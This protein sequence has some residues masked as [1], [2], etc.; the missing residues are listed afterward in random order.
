MN[1]SVKFK[2]KLMFKNIKNLKNIIL[3][4]VFIP[5][6]L[7]GCAKHIND[8]VLANELGSTP[9][10]NLAFI[11]G[12][13]DAEPMPNAQQI[14]AD[15]K[16]RYLRYYYAPWDNPELFK[17]F[18]K[19]KEDV[20]QYNNRY[21]ENPGWGA[22]QQMHSIAWAKA[23]KQNVAFDSFP[24][25]KIKA[26]TVRATNMR[27]LPTDAP[28]FE[29]W[30]TA[31]Q[32][33]PFDTLQASF[34]E[35]DVPVYV[36]QTTNDGQW[37]LVITPYK[38]YGWIKSLDV[39][40]VNDNFMRTFKSKDLV[41]TIKDNKSIY[42]S[43]MRY[44]QSTRYGKLFPLEQDAGAYYKVLIATRGKDGYAD[45]DIGY[46][47]K[48]YAYPWPILV[49]KKTIAE[50]ANILLN[51]SYGWGG[52]Y[53]Y[54]DCSGTMEELFIPFGIWLPK[55]SADQAKTGRFIDLEGLTTPQ[56]IEKIRQSGDPFLTLFWMRG[57]MMLYIGMKDNTV[58]VFHNP[59]GVSITNPPYRV[60]I[61]RAIISKANLGEHYGNV[62]STYLDR[63]IGMTLLLPK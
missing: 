63:V 45:F 19:I 37:Q 30:Y 43:K 52:L 59:W 6:L 31:G 58:Y 7:C 61:G 55:Y 44:S 17:S 8:Q 36:L 40:Y 38:S 34:L 12:G 41:V 21:I 4:A 47:N 46:L 56:K 10:N 2:T 54:R 5:L 15:L 13:K 18:D 28:S 50:F 33:Y 49:N 62:P 25:T 22:N 24:N 1:I 27:A 26:I 60:I 32:G 3:C 14:A 51:G 11:K 23:L 16:A 9:Q 48:K 35:A 53:G 39:A 57:H 42:D 29:D 20:M